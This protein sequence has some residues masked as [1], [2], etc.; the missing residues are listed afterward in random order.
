MKMTNEQFD[1]LR[2][3]AE[4]L[5]HILTFILAVSEIV[6][7]KYGV[8]LSAIVAAFNIMTGSIIKSLRASYIPGEE[9]TEDDATDN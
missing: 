8:E 4:L 6:G 7:F 5:G 2:L 9:V 3:W 1:R